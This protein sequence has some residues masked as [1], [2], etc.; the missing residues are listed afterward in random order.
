MRGLGAIQAVLQAFLDLL[1]QPFEQDPQDAL[2]AAAASIAL[3]AAAGGTI[4]AGSEDTIQGIGG[5]SLALVLVWMAVTAVVARP[6][7]KHHAIARNLGLVSLWIAA[8]LVFFLGAGVV[9]PD[10]EAYARRFGVVAIM[11]LVLVPVHMVRSLPVATAMGMTLALWVTTG[12]L[13]WT[14]V[15]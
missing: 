7:R 9:V 10:R 14:L 15:Y 3:V 11:L 2:K 6:D 4:A 1:T 13:A 12:L 5:P 8:T